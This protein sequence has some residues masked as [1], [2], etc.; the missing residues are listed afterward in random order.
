MLLVPNFIESLLTEYYEFLYGINC[1]EHLYSGPIIS[2]NI[3]LVSIEMMI[4]Q[5][6]KLYEKMLLLA[7]NGDEWLDI[8]GG[9][10]IF[11]LLQI[12]K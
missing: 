12:C 2:C 11:K 5:P 10:P 8:M 3:S 4:G 1:Y 9:V 6:I 7:A